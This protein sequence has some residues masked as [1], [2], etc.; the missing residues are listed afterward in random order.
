MNK[1]IIFYEFFVNMNSIDKTKEPIF[2]ALF[3]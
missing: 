1:S 2:K 3:Y